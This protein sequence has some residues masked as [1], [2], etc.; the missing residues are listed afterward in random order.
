MEETLSPGR[1]IDFVQ[2]EALWGQCQQYHTMQKWIAI[3][4][5]T[6]HESSCNQYCTIQIKVAA[7]TLQIPY[8][9]KA[10]ATDCWYIWAEGDIFIKYYTKIPSRFRVCFDTEK[11]NWKHREVFAP[12]SFVPNKEEFSFIWVQFRLIRRQPWLHRGQTWRL[13][14]AIRRCWGAAVDKKPFTDAML[15]RF[16]WLKWHLHLICTICLYLINIDHLRGHSLLGTTWWHIKLGRD[17]AMFTVL[18]SCRRGT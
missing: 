8:M 6:G 12:L 9:V 5:T 15:S 10:W 4:E 2:V 1:P 17:T 7:N 14:M 18:S 3:I 13:F 16:S 11:L